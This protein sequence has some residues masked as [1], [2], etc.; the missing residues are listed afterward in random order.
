MY[1][2]VWEG[3]HGDG[4]GGA[5]GKQS[6]YIRGHRGLGSCVCGIL[7]FGWVGGWVAALLSIDLLCIDVGNGF[8]TNEDSYAS[9]FTPDTKT[10]PG[11]VPTRATLPTGRRVQGSEREAGPT[12]WEGTVPA[13]RGGEGVEGSE[14]REEEGGGGGGGCQEGGKGGKT[15]AEGTKSGGRDRRRWGGKEEGASEDDGGGGGR[16]GGGAGG[17]VCGGGGAA[18]GRGGVGM[19]LEEGGSMDLN[20]GAMKAIRNEAGKCTE[21]KKWW[22]GLRRTP[23]V[24]SFCYSKPLACPRALSSRIDRVLVLLPRSLASSAAARLFLSLPVFALNSHWWTWCRLA[25][26]IFLFSSLPLTTCWHIYFQVRFVFAPAL[27]FAHTQ[28]N[29]GRRPH[30]IA[31]HA[32]IFSK[33]KEEAAKWPLAVTHPIV[34]F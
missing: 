3:D 23:F 25:I 18:P 12:E 7:F 14:G 1:V 22:K 30:V 24:F 9:N 13:T 16:A 21:R 11:V 28:R 4:G 10:I 26:F 29:R 15:R 20:N 27:A 17:H 6:Q 32:T 5:A 8:L 34:L 19:A 2:F 31:R 33:N